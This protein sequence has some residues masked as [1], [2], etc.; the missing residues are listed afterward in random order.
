MDSQDQDIYGLQRL[1][2]EVATPD[3]WDSH[4]RSPLHFVS[5]FVS[6]W[7]GFYVATKIVP[8]CA[9]VLYFSMYILDRVLFCCPG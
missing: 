8:V 3:S 6:I 5:Q 2:A 7:F 4:F 9:C 1:R